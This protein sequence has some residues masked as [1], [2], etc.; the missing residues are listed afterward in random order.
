MKLELT[1]HDL[2]VILLALHGRARGQY[3]S[4]EKPSGRRTE[5]LA[6]KVWKIITKPRK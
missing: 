4:G 3:D 2:K 1:L 5:A 6:N